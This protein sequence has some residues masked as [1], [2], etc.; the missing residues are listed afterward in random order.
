MHFLNIIALT[1]TAVAVA[2]APSIFDDIRNYE[3]WT[4]PDTFVQEQISPDIIV[5]NQRNPDTVDQEQRSPDTVGQENPDTDEQGQEDPVTVDLQQTNPETWTWAQE[6]CVGSQKMF[7]CTN[8]DI[9]NG[10]VNC[11][12]VPLETLASAPPALEEWCST[13]I[14]CI[15][16]ENGLA[17]LQCVEKVS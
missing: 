1:V 17:N 12:Y 10:P 13:T 3:D 14:C 15:L 11:T 16:K 7:C 8:H 5:Q 9:T 6:T 2:A 4:S